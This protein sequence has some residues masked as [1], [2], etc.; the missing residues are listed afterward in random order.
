MKYVKPERLWI[1]N[2]SDLDERWV[3]D[4]IAEDPTI[5]GLGDVVVR[6][7]E[8]L[9]PRAGRLDLLHFVPQ[10][11]DVK[12]SK[13]PLK[14]YW[15]EQLGYHR[16][17]STYRYLVMAAMATRIE[18]LACFQ[19]TKHKTLA[20]IEK[21]SGE[22]LIQK[23]LKFARVFDEFFTALRMLRRCAKTRSWACNWHACEGKYSPCEFMPLCW[24]DQYDDPNEWQKTLKRRG[25]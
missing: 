23:P 5:L 9:Q 21:Y 10:I 8:R 25:S 20:S 4:R 2:Q 22:V 19:L 17:L 18:K 13:I 3:Q 6:D 16:Q 15:Y 1:N 24:W 7:K 12:T 11:T 14:Q